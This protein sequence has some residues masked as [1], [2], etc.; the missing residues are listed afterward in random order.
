MSGLHICLMGTIEVTRDGA[1]VEIPGRRVRALLALLALSADQV[2]SIERLAEGLWDH[3]PPQRVRGS[4]QTYVGRLRRAIG[5]DRVLTRPS[6]YV[7]RVDRRDVDLLDFYDRVEAAA[8][9]VDPLEERRRLAAALATWRGEPFG[10]PPS[11]WL[12]RYESPLWVERHLQAVER[13]VDLD[14]IAGDHARCAAELQELAAR[15]PLRESMWLRWLRALHACGRTAEALTQY[16]TLRTRLVEELGTAPPAELQALHLEL[17]ETAETPERPAPASV[18]PTR[19]PPAVS[20][21]TGRTA[22]LAELEALASATPRPSVVALHGPAG[23]GKTTLAL[24]WAQRIRL[25]F[26]D[27]QLFV[28]L[29]GFGPDAPLGTAEALGMLLGGL[30][31][32]RGGLP[33]GEDE[34]TALWRNLLADRQ[35]LV[36]L[37]NAR[38]SDQVRPL[39][40][41][42]PSLVVVTSRSQLR[43]LA[44][45]EGAGRV[46]VDPMP[47]RESVDLL[48]HRLGA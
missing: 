4:L 32:R 41:G 8:Q 47:A 45:R 2:V 30:G 16:E 15:N 28:D 33:I 24:H 18:V 42:G 3:D 9:C 38:E 36:V 7:L 11:L 20:G 48:A 21:F 25:G 35:M 6:G 29:G 27:G 5:A 31:V 23:T 17:L 46:V 37:D 26:P 43:S 44:T 19:L 22:Q 39:L 13:R 40:P 34:R 12:G 10:E 14:L 1:A